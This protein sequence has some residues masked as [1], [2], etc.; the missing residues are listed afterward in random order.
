MYG[1]QEITNIVQIQL[2]VT[3]ACRLERAL[4]AAVK[5][6]AGTRVH[7][8]NSTVNKTGMMPNTNRAINDNL[9][10]C[11]ATSVTQDRV[12]TSNIAVLLFAT[13]KVNGLIEPITHNPK[14]IS[15]VILMLGLLWKGCQT[16]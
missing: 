12:L 16:Q 8:L 9:A 14:I 13:T 1:T 10:C 3:I 7:R 11:P 15:L 6:N 4:F 2:T 5:R